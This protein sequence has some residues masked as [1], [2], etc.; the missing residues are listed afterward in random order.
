[1]KFT[2]TILI[3]LLTSLTFISSYGQK[4]DVKKDVVSFDDVPMLKIKGGTN[5]IGTPCPMVNF[6]TEKPVFIFI[7]GEYYPDGTRWAYYQIRFVDFDLS[8]Y[9]KGSYKNALLELFKN[10][11]INESGEV[12]KEDAEKFVRLYG[13][14][15][16]NELI[17]KSR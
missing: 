8:Y 1:M 9:A 17:I 3:V 12:K 11:L 7:P 10:G 5:A 14:N 16:P 15:P 13:W 2:K 6:K 4:I